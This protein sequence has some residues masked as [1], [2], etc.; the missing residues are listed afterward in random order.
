MITWWLFWGKT[1]E[2]EKL[3]Q[4]LMR[5]WRLNLLLFVEASG[6]MLWRS[7]IYSYMG[8]D[9]V[10]VP[11]EN[12]RK[13]ISLWMKGENFHE[14]IKKLM[15]WRNPTWLLHGTRCKLP[16]E[17][18]LIESCLKIRWRQKWAS[19]KTSET[20]SSTQTWKNSESF[21][22]TRIES[23]LIHHGP[24]HIYQLATTTHN[25]IFCWSCN[26]RSLSTLV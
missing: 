18:F 10:D 3:Y 4:M 11:A 6:E 26:T 17:T 9:F 15:K 5:L 7:Q 23:L 12:R 19:A 24:F 2:S 22:S 13:M 20:F 21:F 14:K 25:C 16:S 8:T 1:Y